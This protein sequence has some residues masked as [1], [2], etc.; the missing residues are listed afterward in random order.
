MSTQDAAGDPVGTMRGAGVA[1][2]SGPTADHRSRLRRRGRAAL[3]LAALAVVVAP[4]LAGCG[5][6]GARD[7]SSGAGGEPGVVGEAPVQ[8]G[9]D[10]GGEESGGGDAPSEDRELVI[11]GSL[12][13]TVEDPLEAADE[14]ARIVERAGGRVDGRRESAPRDAGSG[15]GT[16][17]G[18]GTEF[19]PDYSVDEY[20]GY[21]G[22]YS[23][24]NG[25][26]AVLELRIPSTRLMETLDELEALGEREELVLSSDDVTF[27]RRD[28]TARIS[29]LESSVARLLALQDA[30]A[31]LDDLIALESAISDRQA[32]LESLQA[33]ERY[34]ED[35]V[36]LSTI[37]LTLGS[38]DV[39][40]VDEPDSFWSG[41]ATGWDAL[42]AFL[43]GALVV[44]G[45][46]LPWLIALGVLALVA[47]AILRRAWTRRSKATSDAQPVSASAG[48]DA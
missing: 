43:G 31:D 47:W 26:G 37:T 11:T 27:E 30:A 34:Y 22:Y 5:A 21:S 35:Q 25:G 9:G 40:P 8:D 6:I 13:V 4:L 17:S 29:A 2:R 41:L 44:A 24:G 42:L 36:S 14:A 15:D 38:E 10:L 19:A 46:L 32:E 33:Q 45:V 1:A 23:F 12:Y 39:A 20:G 48:S 18:G 3:S 16:S 7:E 28:L